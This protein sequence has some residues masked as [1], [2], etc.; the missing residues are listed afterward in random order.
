MPSSSR[1]VLRMPSAPTAHRART[2]APAPRVASCHLV[3]GLHESDDLDA[4]AQRA[5]RERREPRAQQRLGARLRQRE[6]RLVVEA[7]PREQPAAVEGDARAD[8]D[9]LRPHGVADAGRVERGE[10]RRVDAD[11][12]RRARR[13]GAPL[14][15]D[16]I[17]AAL[18]EQAREVQ[19]DG[20]G[21]DDRDVVEPAHGIRR[22][23]SSRDG[24]PVRTRQPG[25]AAAAS[26]AAV[27]LRRIDVRP[28]SRM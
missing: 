9:R 18:G 17:G 3:A 20:A 24:T 4:L 19:P 23:S 27:W 21:T 14:E 1:V 8:A 5:G 2:A 12:A 26:S 7:Q 16:D 6:D 25:G 10:A 22:T 11:R 13:L 28:S 15:H